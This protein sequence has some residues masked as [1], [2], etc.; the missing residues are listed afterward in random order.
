[1]VYMYFIGIKMESI[2]ILIIQT[3]P[4]VFKIYQDQEVFLNQIMNHIALG[5]NIVTLNEVINKTQITNV[6]TIHQRAENYND[7][8]DFSKGLL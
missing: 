7:T 6:K 4:L 5:I 3:S 1:M 8:F 2:L